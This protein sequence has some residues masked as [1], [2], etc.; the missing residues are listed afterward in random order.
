M[1]NLKPNLDKVKC[2]Q[3]LSTDS[4]DYSVGDGQAKKKG[5]RKSRAE[6]EAEGDADPNQPPKKRG[7]GKKKDAGIFSFSS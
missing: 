5:G 7:K 3:R 1:S 6:G 2:E 4:Q